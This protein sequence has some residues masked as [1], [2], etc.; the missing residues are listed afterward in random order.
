MQSDNKSLIKKSPTSYFD[1]MEKVGSQ[2]RYQKCS[3][4]L[5][6]LLWLLTSLFIM[7]TS[8]LFFNPKL[9]CNSIG[10]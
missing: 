1:L 4:I 6:L 9:D 5:F 2:G 7:G 8:F 10:L 3:F